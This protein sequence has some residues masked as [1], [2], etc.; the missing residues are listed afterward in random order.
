M[1]N[2]KETYHNKIKTQEEL[3]EVVNNLKKQGK[4]I[5]TTNGVFDILHSGHVEYLKKA[6]ELGNVLIV[7]I[8]SDSSVKKIKGEKR[9]INDEI[10]RAKVLAALEC[11]DFVTIFDETNPSVILDK[12]KPDIHAKGGDYNLPQI[13]EKDIVEKNRGKV[14]LLPE[15]KGFSTTDMI[16]KI[17]KLNQ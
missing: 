12:I 5:V 7:C 2:K 13:I 4:K 6:K 3:A 17:L 11:I 1:N 16:N 15:I 8:N 9:P 14:I 10:S